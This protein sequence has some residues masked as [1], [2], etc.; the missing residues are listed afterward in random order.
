MTSSDEIEA[1]IVA[2]IK[3]QSLEKTIGPD[4]QYWW[5]IERFMDINTRE[6]AEAGWYAILG[7]LHRQPPQ[8]VLDMLAANPLEDLIHYWG[9]DF[10]D[11]IEQTAWD[12][13]QFRNLLTGVWE[14]SSAEIW[15]RVQ[16]VASG[17]R[18]IHR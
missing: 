12:D 1:W 4:H 18:P 14:S 8:Q 15:N 2:Y 6:E 3:A 11:R 17:R 16:L 10:I 5:A 7:I 13:V 9:P